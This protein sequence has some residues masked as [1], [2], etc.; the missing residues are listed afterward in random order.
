MALDV[1][2]AR[3][4]VDS[5]GARHRRARLHAPSGTVELDL[6]QRDGAPARGVDRLQAD[7]LLAECVERIGGFRAVSE[8]HVAALSRGDRNRL[9]LAARA[10]LLGDAVVLVVRCPVDDCAGLADL[11]LST[12]DLL[13]E[14]GPAQ[15]LALDVDTPAGVFSVRPPTGV[16]EAV[17][18]ADDDSLWG[19]LVSGEGDLLGAPG[20]R[21]LDATSQQLIAAALAGLDACADLA[22]VTACPHCGAWIEVELDPF[23]LLVRSLASGEQR[24]LAEVHCLAFHYGWSQA[25]ILALARPRR[26]AYLELIASQIEGRPLLSAG[27]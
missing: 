22:L 18:G 19:L 24:L 27:A 23:E 3:G 7:E 1:A 6:A 11:T 13:G 4:L 10:S 17:S 26:L 12:T 9:A 14:P 16:D 20:W 21:A 8:E 5:S 2:L 15:P 25:E